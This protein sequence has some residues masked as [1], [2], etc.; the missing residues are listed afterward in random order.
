MKGLLT[1]WIKLFATLV[2][3]DK[4]NDDSTQQ[5]PMSNGLL[6]S[7]LTIVMMGDLSLLHH[8]T[9]SNV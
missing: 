4:L 5:V 8:Y 7:N 2:F 9:V 3:T 6:G 1:V